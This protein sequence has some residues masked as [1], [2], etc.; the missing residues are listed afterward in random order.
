MSNLKY[1]AIVASGIA[2]DQRVPIPATLVP[3][4]ALVEL[5]AKKAAGYY[6]VD[7]PPDPEALA[8]TRGRDL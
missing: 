5:D 7:S 4:D 6:S 2:V 3:A 1:D 8:R